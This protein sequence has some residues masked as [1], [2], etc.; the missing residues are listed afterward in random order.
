MIIAHTSQVFQPLTFTSTSI[1][2]GMMN[3][4]VFESAIA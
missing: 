2:P 4:A 3:R 1:P